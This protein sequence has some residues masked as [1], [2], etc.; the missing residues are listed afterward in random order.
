MTYTPGDGNLFS[1]SDTDWTLNIPTT[2]ALAVGNYEVAA[3]STDLAGNVGM[4][5]TTNELTVEAPTNTFANDGWTAANGEDPDGPT[6]PAIAI[7]YDAFTSIQAAIDAAADGGTVTVAAS[8]T[9]DADYD[10][11]V[12]IGKNLTLQGETGG[13]AVVVD[14]AGN[15][16]VDIAS[17]ATDVTLKD[18]TVTG[19]GRHGI[20][21]NL[22]G[23]NLVLNGTTVEDSPRYGLRADGLNSLNI[24]DSTFANNN[25][26]GGFAGVGLLGGT[27]SVEISGTDFSGES[28]PILNDV[29]SLTVNAS[30]NFWGAWLA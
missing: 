11:S 24:E 1:V 16:T 4:D 22:A 19:A 5:G 8:S 29:G 10:E 27:A 20:R 17:G 18:I 12:L 2:A 6:G 3:S 30:E 21:A 23:L 28:V 26:E 25:T 9:G 7:G 14:G 15:F 13:S